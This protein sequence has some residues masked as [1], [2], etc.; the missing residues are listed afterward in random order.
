MTK[1]NEQ[2]ISVVTAYSGDTPDSSL[3]VVVPRGARELTGA[4]RGSRFQV[5]VDGRNR[6]IYELLEE[7]RRKPSC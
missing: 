7:I 2:L 4:R 5:K 6:L 3:I 1:P